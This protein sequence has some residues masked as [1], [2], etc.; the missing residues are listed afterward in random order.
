MYSY[1]TERNGNKI[2][3]GI[4]FKMLYFLSWKY[5]RRPRVT[6]FALK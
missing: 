2:C 4:E 1:P 3:V 6:F 5:S